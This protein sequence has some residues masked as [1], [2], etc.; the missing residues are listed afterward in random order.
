M[1]KII[2]HGIEK[3]IG[4]TFLNISISTQ[5]RADNRHIKT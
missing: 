2:L 3:Y 4:I 5:Q 1:I